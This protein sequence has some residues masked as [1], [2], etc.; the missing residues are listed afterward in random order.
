MK[1]YNFTNRDIVIVLLVIIIV[2]LL[3]YPVI[4]DFIGFKDG[5]KNGDRKEWFDNNR[6]KG[7]GD[8][9]GYYAVDGKTYELFDFDPNTADST[10]LLRLGLKPWQVR[11]I[12]KYRAAGGRYRT[13]QDFARL[14]GL[15][16]EQYKRLEPYI[17]IEKE[18]MAADVIGQ[19]EGN[20]SKDSVAYPRKL[21]PGETVNINTAD[22]SLLKRI[23]GIGSY[24]ARQIVN[25]RQRLGGIAKIDQLKEI[26]GFPESAFQYMTTGVSSV[27]A[28]SQNSGIAKIR[29]NQ[30]EV[31]DLAK[32]PYIRYVQAKEI[33]Q[34]RRL[35]GPIKSASVLQRLPSFSPDDVKRLEPYLDFD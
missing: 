9:G 15:T 8:K 12:Y 24:Y 2:C 27:S 17:K 11:N 34:Y 3:L 23:P 7:K 29:I 20:I 19:N 21:K 5:N 13:P 4:D 26:E 18:V 10:Q 33:F 22:T 14:Y 32:H 28:A 16:L 31:K 25:K 6:G 1:K 30:L 35:R